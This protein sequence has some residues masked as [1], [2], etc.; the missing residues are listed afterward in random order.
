MTLTPTEQEVLEGYPNMAMLIGNMNDTTRTLA[1]MYLS[2][3]P[4]PVINQLE[5]SIPS[6]VELNESNDE[7]GLRQLLM[8]FGADENTTNQLMQMRENAEHSIT[9]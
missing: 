3:L 6:I 9:E 4:E 8:A 5:A 1:F 2:L 7:T